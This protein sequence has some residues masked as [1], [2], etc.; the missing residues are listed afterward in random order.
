MDSDWGEILYVLAL[1]T[2]FF[3]ILLCGTS[4]TTFG[5][6]FLFLVVVALGWLL[7]DVMRPE[8]AKQRVTALG[9]TFGLAVPIGAGVLSAVSTTK[10][11]VT[12][13]RIAGAWISA[14]NGVGFP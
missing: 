6:A 8:T 4:M 7:V 11:M 5:A 13:A 9:V 2:L 14:R 3:S 12:A 1:T 10:T